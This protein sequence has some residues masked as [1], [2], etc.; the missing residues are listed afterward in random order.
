M[1]GCIIAGII[2]LTVIALVILNAVYVRRLS[3]ELLRGLD[4]LPMVPDPLDTPKRIQELEAVLEKHDAILGLTVPYKALDEIR[5]GLVTMR[6]CIEVGDEE[7]YWET[8]RLVGSLLSELARL[9]RLSAE[10]VF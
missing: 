8:C 9:E 6:A 7:T 10:N 2:L 3:E 5:E 4:Q 1:K